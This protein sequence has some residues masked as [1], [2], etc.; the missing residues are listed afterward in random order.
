MY[1]RPTEDFTCHVRIDTIRFQSCIFCFSRVGKMQLFSFLFSYQSNRRGCCLCLFNVFLFVGYLIFCA[2]WYNDFRKLLLPQQ[3]HGFTFWN[4]SCPSLSWPN[5][6]SDHNQ[7]IFRY[8]LYY[9]WKTPLNFLR[10][11]ATRS[12]GWNPLSTTRRSSL[13]YA[14]CVKYFPFHI[15]KIN[16]LPEVPAKKK[17]QKKNMFSLVQ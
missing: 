2:I 7:H 3:T 14:F 4:F 6:R 15:T 17:K 16:F 12:R 5:V 8:G 13:T 1:T 10:S 11:M 9:T